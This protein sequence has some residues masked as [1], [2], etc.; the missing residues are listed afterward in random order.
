MPWRIFPAKVCKELKIK[1]LKRTKAA[2]V[3]HTKREICEIEYVG[4]LCF[5]N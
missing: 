1:E 3:S 5:I 2:T 4:M